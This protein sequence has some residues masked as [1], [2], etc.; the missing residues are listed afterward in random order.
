MDLS[1]CGLSGTLPSLS[2][3]T[4][5][6]F[7]DLSANFLS[8]S[9]PSIPPQ[10]HFLRDFDASSNQ[11]GGYVPSWISE[12][13][14]SMYL[15]DNPFLCPYPTTLPTNVK[16]GECVSKYNPQL[17]YRKSEFTFFSS[18]QVEYGIKVFSFFCF[19]V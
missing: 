8:G 18:F 19:V 17:S 2:F 7:I 1:T 9:L 12:V 13:T 4:K 10:L 14:F 11:L 3:L 5:I 6:E 16:L 15:V